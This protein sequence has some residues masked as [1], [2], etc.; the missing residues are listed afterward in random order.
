MTVQ[1]KR[2]SHIPV[3]LLLILVSFIWGTSFIATEIALKEC[4]VL[5]LLILRLS[6]ASLA[7]LCMLLWRKEWKKKFTKRDALH[8]L[9]IGCLSVSL[10]Q[11]MQIG[12]N[13]VS[14]ASVTSLFITA[15]PIVLCVFGIAFFGEKAG[16][17][18]I[19]GI[20]TGFAGSYLIATKGRLSLAGDSG[21]FLALGLILLNS[22]MWAG[23]STLAKKT[24]SK[25]SPLDVTGLMTV[26][27]FLFFIPF[28]F[29][30]E[31]LLKTNVF[32]EIAHLSTRTILAVVYLSF[33]C[34]IAGYALWLYC[35]TRG[36]VSNAGYYL[37]LEP[38]FTLLV[39]PLFVGNQLNT[40]LI[41][42]GVAI[43]LGLF[44]IHVDK[45][46]R[47]PAT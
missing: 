32:Q 18:K 1:P 33:V 38:V 12:A 36:E 17:Y 35:L 20:A 13:K 19:I 2:F 25:Y 26:F 34:T 30:L 41:V 44:F 31:W 42:G 10:Y 29:P 46:R 27:G 3:P 4:S 28:L 6:I 39:A 24:A 22:L 21:Y 14:N 8:F 11:L 16:R 15:H 9:V 37:Y 5:T 43:F 45:R 23:Y 47:A 7:F 40:H